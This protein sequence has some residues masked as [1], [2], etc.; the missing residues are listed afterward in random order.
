M[1][2]HETTDPQIKINL[3]Q[4]L[5]DIADASLTNRILENLRDETIQW[6]VRWLLTESLEGLQESAKDSLMQMLESLAIDERVR[7]GIA[8]TLGTWRMRESIPYLRNAIQNKVVPHSWQQRYHTSCGYI[9]GRITRVLN[10]LDDESVVPILK[11]AFIQS[12]A[13]SDQWATINALLEYKDRAEEIAYQ[14]LERVRSSVDSGKET[15]LAY[16]RSL[17]TKSL[18]P[19]LRQLLTTCNVYGID[20]WAQIGII[21]GLAQVAD[22]L[23]TVEA[24][25][26]MMPV[27]QTTE[28]EYLRSAIYQALYRISQ[29]ARVRLMHDGQIEELQS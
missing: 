15:L 2:L 10:S 26:E 29:R 20:E 27:M 8:A 5:R 22:D 16:M 13:I 19:E 17:A 12:S 21:N 23:E 14:L 7:V 24:L 3:A 4:A 11:Q 25:Q 28:S 1:L 6:Q 18:V 9:W